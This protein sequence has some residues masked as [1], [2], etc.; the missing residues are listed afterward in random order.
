MFNGVA[1]GG[2]DD[3]RKTKRPKKQKQNCIT[4]INVMKGEMQFLF[5]MC[6]RASIYDM[7]EYAAQMEEWIPAR[8]AGSGS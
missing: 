8:N 1:V 5:E 4:K 3:G 2:G 7:Q 6:V